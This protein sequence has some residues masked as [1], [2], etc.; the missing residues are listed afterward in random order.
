MEKKYKE[1]QEKHSD[2]SKH[3]KVI[4]KEMCKRVGADYDKVNFKKAEW[5]MDYR[6]TDIEQESFMNWLIKY[7]KNNSEARKEILSM[8]SQSNKKHL[9]K[10]AMMFIFDYGWA[11]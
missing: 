4:L 6:W 9:E 11:I 8:P 5:F 3:L 1:K 7:L 2:H 10:C